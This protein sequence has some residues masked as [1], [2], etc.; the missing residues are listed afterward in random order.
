MNSTTLSLKIEV[1]SHY[2]IP[3]DL[4]RNLQ[5]TFRLHWATLSSC[6][7]VSFHALSLALKG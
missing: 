7:P 2:Q 1:E 5:L 3:G 6:L 4:V